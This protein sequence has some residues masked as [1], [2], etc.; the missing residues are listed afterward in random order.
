MILVKDFIFP[1]LHSLISASI[2]VKNGNFCP[3][4]WPRNFDIDESVDILLDS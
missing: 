1:G 2:K 4:I 3:I